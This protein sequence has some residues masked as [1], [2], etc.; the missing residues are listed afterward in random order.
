MRAVQYPGGLPVAMGLIR[1]FQ[2]RWGAEIKGYGQRTDGTI[3][4]DVALPPASIAKMLVEMDR[5]IEAPGE[6]RA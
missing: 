6:S 1:E 5:S 4:V 3:V 2:E